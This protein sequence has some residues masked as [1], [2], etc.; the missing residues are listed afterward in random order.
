MLRSGWVFMGYAPYRDKKVVGVFVR[1]SCARFNGATSLGLHRDR[2]VA[3][4]KTRSRR[5][6]Q[7]TRV[8]KRQTDENGRQWAGHAAEGK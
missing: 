8:Q 3:E 7:I 6:R 1:F 4:K 2:R 5:A